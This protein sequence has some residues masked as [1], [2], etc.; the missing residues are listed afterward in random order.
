MAIPEKYKT[1]LIGRSDIVDVVSSYVRLTKKSGNHWGLCPFHGEKTPSFAVNAERQSFKCFGCGKGGDVISF[2]ME[3]EHL[4]F[5]DALDLLADRANMPRLPRDAK[6]EEESSK[7]KR[8]LELNRDAARWFFDQLRGEGGQPCRD[9]A[10]RRGLSSKYIVNFGLGYAPDSWDS[11][12]N[13]MRQKGYTDQELLDAALA[14]PGRRGGCYD[15]FRNRLMFPVVD[16]RGSVIG[17]SG[18]II[19][20]G[21][22]KYLNSPETAV[23]KKSQNLFAMNLAKKSKSGYIIL[24]EGNLDVVSLHQAGFDSAVASLGTSLT[25]EQARLISRYVS[26]VLLCYDGDNAGRKAT[27][28]AIGIL[29][30]LDLKV[31]VLELPGA[32]DPDEFIKMNGADA[33]RN[34]LEGSAGQLDYRLKLIEEQF[35]PDHDGTRVDYLKKVVALLARLPSQVERELYAVRTAQRLGVSQEAVIKDVERVRRGILKGAA[36]EEQKKGES[37]NAT[38]WKRPYE[39]TGKSKAEEGLLL[40]LHRDPGLLNRKELPK[41]EDFSVPLLGRFYRVLL[42]RGSFSFSEMAEEFSADE[43]FVLVCITEMQTD[44][45]QAETALRDYIKTI[46]PQWSDDLRIY[47]QQRRENENKGYGG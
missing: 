31:R 38:D 23:F 28:R 12:R 11:L 33:F 20:D 46:A 25:P 27:D 7:R 26:E 44:M 3:I 21:E 39:V 8:I 37:V 5:M 17:F 29:N 9:Y 1:E 40:L 15:T 6:D 30:K 42:E 47:A 10:A 18:R 16:V 4:G 19:G 22:P 24:T 13:A 41:P 32:K 14:K 34:I 45:S 2:I 36:R 43:M 35:S